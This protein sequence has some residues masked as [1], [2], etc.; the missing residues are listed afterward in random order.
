VLKG[1]FT[2]GDEKD[3]CNFVSQKISQNMNNGNTKISHRSVV[4]QILKL[5]MF[6]LAFA[7]LFYTALSSYNHTNSYTTL[8]NVKQ[9]IIS[10]EGRKEIKTIESKDIAVCFST[11]DIDKFYITLIDNKDGKY[12]YMSSVDYSISDFVEYRNYSNT[13]YADTRTAVK[14]INGTKEGVNFGF[15]SSDYTFTE[16]DQMNWTFCN[17]SCNGKT[18]ILYYDDVSCEESNNIVDNNNIID[19]PDL[20]VKK[21]IIYLYPKQETSVN[22][23]LGKLQNITYTYP[24]YNDSWNVIAEPDGRL[25]DIK[26]GRSLYSLY[27]EGI[28]TTEPDMIDGFVIKGTDVIPFLEEKLATL[29]LTEREADEFIIYWLPEL[30]K[31]PYNFIR[32]ETSEEI[33]SVMPL[34]ITPKP[35]AVIRVMMEFKALDKPINIKEQELKTPQRN[36]FVVVEWGGTEIK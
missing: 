31:N 36:G 7:F 4:K 21:P 9:S 1:K 25:T 18:Y 35:D 2:V 6:I 14:T 29:G 30:E 17:F 19:N 28:T 22:I 8:D 16:G 23:K 15:V 20:T 3:F 34:E 11:D 27:W 32:F 10:K 26:T 24:K 13:L 33:N 12:K 5:V